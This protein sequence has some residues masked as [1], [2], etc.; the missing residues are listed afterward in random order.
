MKSL[1]M[2]VWSSTR[3]ADTLLSPVG[4][5]TSSLSSS[6]DMRIRSVPTCSTSICVAF[7]S[8]SLP[9]DFR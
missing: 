6:L 8:M 4:M 3:A 2:P 5:A 9:A 7:G 1:L